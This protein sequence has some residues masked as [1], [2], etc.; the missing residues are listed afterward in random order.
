MLSSLISKYL[1]EKIFI[2]SI[3]VILFSLFFGFYDLHSAGQWSDE[4]YYL[5]KGYLTLQL[6]K[7][8]DMLDSF[9]YEEGADHPLT[10]TYAYGLASLLDLKNMSDEYYS[11]DLKIKKPIFQ[12]D[13]KYSRLIPVILST[14]TVLL[15]F[16]FAIRYFSYFVALSSSLILAALPHFVGFSHFA[17]LESWCIFTFSLAVIFSIL[18]VDTKKIKFVILAGIMSGISLTVKQSNILIYVFFIIFY[19]SQKY[20]F[21]DRILSYKSIL[22]IGASSF[23]TI[24]ITYPMPFFHPAEFISK[25]Y[26]MWF[27]NGGKIPEVIFGH[28]I[29]APF[30]YYFLA[31]SITTPILVLLLLIPGFREILKNRKKWIYLT[32]LIWFSV[33]FF[34]LFFSARQ[35]MVRYVIQVYVP[36]SI[37]AALGLESFSKQIVN[38]SKTR[39]KNKMGYALFI[40]LILYLSYILATTTPYYLTY[41]NELVGGTKN[42]YNKKL[43]LIGWYGEGMRGVGKYLESTARKGDK[44]GYAVDAGYHA[45]YDIEGIDEEK[46]S[47]NETYNY[48]VVSYF[49]VIRGGFNEKI[50]EN[51]Y[52]VV[53]REKAKGFDIAR[54]YKRIK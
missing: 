39:H 46:Y 17:S 2:T 24:F 18:Y 11:E 16:L 27:M 33:P 15:T 35:H 48:V 14:L 42:V 12:Y 47:R 13:L 26:E 37:I 22:I 41:F 7:S 34:M 30:F 45:I 6:I 10:S 29:G 38:K 1:N 19:I 51:D 44:V 49:G 50:L 4:K 20:Y 25:S 9:F 53:Y 52:L 8:G 3:F 21:K 23:I 28:M 31:L 5:E 36:L 32:L 43:F 54:V 40:I